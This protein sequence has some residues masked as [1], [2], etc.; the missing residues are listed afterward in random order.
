MNE[1][2]SWW[3]GA[4]ALGGVTVGFY[5]TTGRPLG[6]SGSWARLA[7]VRDERNHEKT[8]AAMQAAPQGADDALM[9]ATLAEFGAD[10]AEK[11]MSGDP[12]PAS[13]MPVKPAAPRAPWTAHA[14]FLVMLMAGGMLATLASGGFEVSLAMDNAYSSF[15]GEGWSGFAFLAL[16]GMLVGFGTQ[17]AGGCTSGHGLSGC[18]R[19]VPASLYATAMFFGTA[20]AVSAL[21]EV[22]RHAS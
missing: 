19:M 14:A 7:S 15:F 20:V 16:G 18:A 1:Y 22:I 4:L 2:W 8:Q 11:I 3:M 17:M 9:K 5:L 12:A 21:L 6:V 13:A 10:V